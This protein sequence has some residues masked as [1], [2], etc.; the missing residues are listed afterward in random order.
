MPPADKTLNHSLSKKGQKLASQKHKLKFSHNTSSLSAT[1]LL[2]LNSTQN[3]LSDV[4][5]LR[6]CYL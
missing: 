1:Y 4:V 3:S 5:S 6:K 2:L